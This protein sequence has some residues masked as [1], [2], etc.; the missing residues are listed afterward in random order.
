MPAWFFIRR[1]QFHIFGCSLPP[2]L[3]VLLQTFLVFAVYFRSAGS[4]HNAAGHLSGYFPLRTTP[5]KG[6]KNT[7]SFEHHC[8]LVFGEGELEQLV[9]VVLAKG[10]LKKL[11]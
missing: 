7:P 1:F 2:A 8:P 4:S 6:L 5:V 11:M 9:K 10:R 3:Q